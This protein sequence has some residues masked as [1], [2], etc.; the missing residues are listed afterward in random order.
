MVWCGNQEVFTMVW[1][2]M[3]A[4]SMLLPGGPG[5]QKETRMWVPPSALPSTS[6]CTCSAISAEENSNMANRRKLSSWP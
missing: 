2:A 1:A 5:A 6:L 4:A 3:R